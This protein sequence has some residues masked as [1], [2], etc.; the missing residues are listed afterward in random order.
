MV[1]R[2]LWNPGRQVIDEIVL[3]DVALVH[4]EQMHSRSWWI[5]IDLQDGT[6]W[7]G[8]FDIDTTGRMM[9]TEQETDVAWDEDEEHKS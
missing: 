8:N 4:V 5:G 7:S 1:R 3:T 9:F 6:Y 2:I